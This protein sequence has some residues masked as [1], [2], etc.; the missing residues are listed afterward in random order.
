M[1]TINVKVICTAIFSIIFFM[2][3]VYFSNK[4]LDIGL[5][6]NSLMGFLTFF[7]GVGLIGLSATMAIG[8]VGSCGK[9]G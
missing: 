6:G 2:A 7:Y 5:S 9:E 4:G 8:G 1:N 3:G